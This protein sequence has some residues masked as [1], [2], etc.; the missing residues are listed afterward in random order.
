MILVWSWPPESWTSPTWTPS[1]NLSDTGKK[2]GLYFLNQWPLWLLIHSILYTTEMI[3]FWVLIGAKIDFQHRKGKQ[4]SGS[5][6]TTGDSCTLQGGY[7]GT[8]CA[9]RQQSNR[10]ELSAGFQS[11]WVMRRRG[12]AATASLPAQARTRS[13][14]PAHGLSSLPRQCPVPPWTYLQHHPFRS[15][16]PFIWSP[17]KWNYSLSLRGS[18]PGLCCRMCSLILW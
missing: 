15:H 8:A 3:E 9:L 13:C 16:G 12:E 5:R 2:W 11:S 18:N 17:C 4:C 1:V 7:P 10:A 6:G 14:L